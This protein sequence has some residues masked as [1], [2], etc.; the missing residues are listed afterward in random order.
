MCLDPIC[1]VVCVCVCAQRN[2]VVVMVIVGALVVVSWVLPVYKF[3]T[4]WPS[5][6]VFVVCGA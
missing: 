2:A 1:V 3:Y 6:N 5:N 4:S